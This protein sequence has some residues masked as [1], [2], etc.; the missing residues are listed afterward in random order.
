[1]PARKWVRSLFGLDE[2]KSNTS[3]EGERSFADGAAYFRAGREREALDCFDRATAC[4]FEH[5]ELSEMRAVCLQ[6][7]NR[8][9]EAIRDFD[10]AIA[11]QSRDC[12]LYFMRALSKG[13]I[14]KY[15]DAARDFEE[16]VRLS[17]E[18]NERN[19][20]YHAHAKEKGY[21]SATAL[22]EF[23]LMN[24]QRDLKTSE[25]RKHFL[26]AQKQFHTQGQL[27]P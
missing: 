6:R 8:D 7:F 17:M 19:E 4:G 13:A 12:N 22:Y 1:M 5:P 23:Y 26:A 11:G 3:P 9:G 25:L 18:V 27:S 10:K 14:G 2:P 15:A 16:A 20:V 21:L 24:N